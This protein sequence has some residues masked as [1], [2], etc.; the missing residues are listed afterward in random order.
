MKSNRIWGL[1]LIILL[2]ILNANNT[3]LKASDESKINFPELSG[4]KILQEYPIYY[5]DNL[6]D[7]INGAADSYLDYRFQDLHIAEYV[8]GDKSYKAE[9]YHHQNS[10]YAFGIYALER[11][12]DYQFIKLGVQGYEES[13]LLHFIKGPY[14]VKVTTNTDEK[15]SLE[16]LHKIAEAVEKNLPGETTLPEIFKSF[17]ESDQI[18]NTEYFVSS[19]FLGYSFLKNAFS[20]KYEKSG[21]KFSI[22]QMEADSE[23][24]ALQMQ[25]K[26]TGRAKS[27]TED[28]PVYVIEDPYNGLILLGLSGKI[29]V[30]TNDLKD[31]D[32]FKEYFSKITDKLKE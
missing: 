9:V 17:P 6:W 30:G 1:V 14:Y 11:S 28:D 29:L 20:V 3:E 23:D 7:Y 8:K 31:I 26:L 32:L 10:I 13:T 18:K 4:F 5:P 22:F 25:K 19:N 24:E 16:I 15:E 27:V 2:L 12:S 21:M